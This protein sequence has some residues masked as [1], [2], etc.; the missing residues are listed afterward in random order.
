MKPRSAL[1]V[2]SILCVTGCGGSGGDSTPP[3]TITV[4][5]NQTLANP[6][7]SI[8]DSSGYM[9]IGV[10]DP[11]VVK[12]DGTYYIFGSHLA[13][14]KTTDLQPW[15]Y[16]S[17]LSAN[18]M[19]DE[20]PLFNTYSTEFAEGIAWTDDFTGSWASDVI[21]APDG[22]FWFYY[23][24]CAQDN[25]DTP[26]RDEV[27]WHRSYLGLAT[28]DSVEGPYVDKG[29]FLRSGYRDEAE[30]A[31]YPVDGVE[32]YNPAVHPNAID[33]AAFYDKDGNLWMVYGSYS[34]GIFVSERTPSPYPPNG[35]NNGWLFH[36]KQRKS[37]DASR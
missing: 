21:Q 17:S 34:G 26:E 20:S 10:H 22:K 16:I 35:I 1:I 6:T 11:S 5:D 27:C 25:P 37:Q 8:A 14:A 29:V 3:E 4:V 18:N 32:T 33:P 31:A 9:D 15:E 19:V 36:T 30:L 23:N 2:S 28:S 12:V 7:T 24:H 13:A